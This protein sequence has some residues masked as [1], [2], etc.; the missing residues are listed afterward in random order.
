MFDCEDALGPVRGRLRSI[1]AGSH[2]S[3]RHLESQI[4]GQ[5]LAGCER[6]PGQPVPSRALPL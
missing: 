3:R 4:C 5:L 6:L 1:R 2:D